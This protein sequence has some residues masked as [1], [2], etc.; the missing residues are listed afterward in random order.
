MQSKMVRIEGNIGTQISHYKLVMACGDE[1]MDSEF[2]CQPIITLV[3]R[4]SLELV[5][6]H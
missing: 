5:F 4:K 1:Q 6:K 2:D 3:M